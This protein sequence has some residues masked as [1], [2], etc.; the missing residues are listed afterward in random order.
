MAVD[1]LLRLL[2]TNPVYRARVVHRESS[3]PEPPEFGEL[4]PPLDDTL[5]GYLDA[6]GIRLYTHQCAAIGLLR[7]GKNVIITTPTAS[8]KTLAF[9]LPVFE[10]LARDPGSRALFLYPTKALTNDQL[11]SLGRMSRFTGIEARPA[12]YDGDTPQSKRAAIRGNS[13]IILSN[14]HELHQILSW[15][16]KWAP[17]LSGL[18]Y[19]VID[20]AH[21]YRGVFG[22]HI[23][24][25]VRRLLRLCRHYGSD[26]RFVLSTA[27]LANPREFATR[28]TGREFAVVGNDGSPRG[29]KHFVLYN[30]FYDGVGDRSTHQETKD[31]LVSCVKEDLQTLCFTGS[32]KMAELITVWARDDL[33]R[34][35]A[36]LAD[37]VAAYRAGYLP[38]ERRSIERRLKEGSMKAVVSTNA[39]ELGIDVGSLDAVLISG[40]PGT[41]MSTRQQAGRAGRKGTESLSIL[42][43]Q[44]DPL[45]QYFMHH[46]GQFFG[47]SHEHAIVDTENP[48]IVSGHLL[49][50]AAELPID[51][52]R[53]REVFATLPALLPELA[54]HNLLR[55]TPRG[56][57]Y[58]GRGRATEA[59]HLGGTIG[60]TFRIL[61]NGRLLETMDRGQ[62]YREAHEG[63]IMIHQGETYVVTE[64][65]LGLHL[66][67]AMP[68]EVD[69]YT[70]PLKEVDLRV[71]EVLGSRTVSGAACF[72]GDVEVTE[73][74]TGYKIKRG[75][76]IIGM[77]PLS[78]PA[79][80]FRTRAF[81]I[82]PGEGM[83]Q[84]LETKGLDPAG[85]LHGAEHA[86]IALMPLHVMC[87]RWDIGGLSS[88]AYGD[89]GKPVI[90]V[91]DG[92]EGGIG[93]A[94]KAFELLPGI[95][96][97]AYELVRDCGC[98]AGCPSCIYSP[99]CGNDNQPLD[100]AAT[101][102]IL[103]GLSRDDQSG[104][105]RFAAGSAPVPGQPVAG[106]VPP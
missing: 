8:G 67:R 49:C 76:T 34:K 55:K 4:D 1:D 47:R 97:T 73:Q 86:I 95:L 27:T 66:I 84:D 41:M 72:F 58:A 53:D 31:L 11:A 37:S 59:V 17:F 52:E 46:P 3:G 98:E 91:Y 78:L 13:R 56:W 24:L 87:D 101:V 50:A 94:E 61:C 39:L 32:R 23:A 82:V 15:H 18:Q 75:D 77:E 33:R 45:D 20:E 35:S 57:V 93:L 28:L 85:G 68:T 2:D 80:G 81:W 63:A 100:K 7:A 64:M 103:G 10:T 19:I 43:A 38:E 65:D 21:R 48:Y 96:S 88:P 83:E 42:V 36:L 102:A 70:Q 26:P 30:P 6:N 5:A 104:T 90:F 16:A 9:T 12:I 106:V 14:P 44:G 51:E 79:L 25:L 74:Y 40:F 89:E 92:Y 29:R 69:Y 105:S 22:S 60:E 54:S 71:V 62:A 99:K